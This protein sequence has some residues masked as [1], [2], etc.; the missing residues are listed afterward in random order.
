[1]APDEVRKA[2]FARQDSR[3][4]LRPP[5][6]EAD[7]LDALELAL[8]RAFEDQ[9]SNSAAAENRDTHHRGSI[10]DQVTEGAKCESPF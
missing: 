8:P 2:E 6:H 3:R 1:L 10:I 9:A 4:R 5:P 7:N